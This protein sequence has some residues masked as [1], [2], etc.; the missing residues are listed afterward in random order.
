M[1]IVEGLIICFF[2]HLKHA[3]ISFDGTFQT[4]SYSHIF[5]RNKETLTDILQR[6]LN[7]SNIELV[8]PTSVCSCVH[9][10]VEI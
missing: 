10:Q 8:K 4:Y 5:I 3:N 9:E 2:Q 6:I 1:P 7:A